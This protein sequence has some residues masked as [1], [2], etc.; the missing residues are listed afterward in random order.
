M[1]GFL[2]ADFL[3]RQEQALTA[4]TAWVAEKKLAVIEDL[5]AGFELLPAAL[6]GLLAGENTGKRIVQVT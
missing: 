5:I 1:R 6:V 3:H 4:L 2:L